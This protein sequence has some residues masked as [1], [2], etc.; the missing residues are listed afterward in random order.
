M[1]NESNSVLD[2]LHLKEEEH[3]P[4][5]ITGR[6]RTSNVG[7]YLYTSPEISRESKSSYYTEKVDIYSLGIILFELWQQFDTAM[8][9]CKT[10]EALRTTKMPPPEFT[11]N[12][13]RQTGLIL[14]MIQDDP[15][16]RPTA[17]ELSNIDVNLI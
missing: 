8:E 11:S 5:F 16:L 3:L 6:E 9:R 7:T 10:I 2:L 12:Y 13:P 14:W 1:E 15:E 4:D 17:G